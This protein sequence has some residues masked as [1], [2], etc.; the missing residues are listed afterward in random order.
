MYTGPGDLIPV[1]QFGGYGWVREWV[2]EWRG[3]EG[4]EGGRGMGKGGWTGDGEE[5]RGVGGEETAMERGMGGGGVG[6]MDRRW[7]G[8]WRGEATRESIAHGPTRSLL[9]RRLSGERRTANG[10]LG[11][12]AAGSFVT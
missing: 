7:E 3:G 5:G 2:G 6:R 12:I 9:R 4:C 11:H 8:G 10:A 1:V